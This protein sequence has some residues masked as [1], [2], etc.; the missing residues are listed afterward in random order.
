MWVRGRYTWSNRDRP[1][2]MPL[3]PSR[4]VSVTIL[5]AIGAQISA[6]VFSL[7]DSTN[8]EAVMDFLFKLAG[9]ITPQ[10]F[11]TRNKAVLVLDNHSAHKTKQVMDLANQLK[12]ELLFTPPYTPELNSIESLWSVVKGDIKK[13]LLDYRQS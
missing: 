5:G 13:H 3:P 6:P 4:G 11:V 8:T 10:P 2:K 12:I 9:V 7:A 1:V